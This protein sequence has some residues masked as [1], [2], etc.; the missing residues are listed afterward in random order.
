[1]TSTDNDLWE[2]RDV[3]LVAMAMARQAANTAKDFIHSDDERQSLAEYN[4]AWYREDK[5]CYMH[6]DAYRN[7]QEWADALLDYINEHLEDDK[8]LI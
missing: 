6:I 8:Y 4:F 2:E 1:M 3:I 5:D 7:T